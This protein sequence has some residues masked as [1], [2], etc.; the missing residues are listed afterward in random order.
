MQLRARIRK[1]LFSL[2]LTNQPNKLERFIKLDQEGLIVT[3]TLNLLGLFVSYDEN[4]VLWIRSL[5]FYS[6][7]FI[8]FITYEWAQ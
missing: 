1:T 5:G 2:Q 4:E 8:F 6:Q 7:H 3:N